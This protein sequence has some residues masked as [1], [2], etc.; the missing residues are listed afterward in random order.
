MAKDKPK[1]GNTKASAITRKYPNSGLASE[2]CIPKED[3][4]WLPSRNLYINHVL[5]GGLLYG[6]ILEIAGEESSGKTLLSLDFL[7]VAQSLGG[8]G[9]FVDAEHAFTAGWAETNGVQLD[10]LYLFPEISVER[11]GDWIADIGIL[12]RSKLKN[13][14]PIVLIVDSTAALDCEAN[15]NSTLVDGKAE[16]GNRAKAIYTMLRRRNELLDKLGICSIFINQLRKK[17]DAQFQDPDT[18]PGG[19]ALKFYASQRM[20]IYRGK[21]INRGSKTHPKRV[22][23]IVS[24]RVAKNKVAPPRPSFQTNVYFSAEAGD[25]VGFDRYMGL[26]ELF[27]GLEVVEKR[28]NAIY[29][30]DEKVATG[31]DNFDEVIRENSKLRAK[32]VSASGLNTVSKTRRQLESLTENL[33]DVVN[34]QKGGKDDDEG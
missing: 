5:G 2:I 34:I 32:L 14:E 33:Y 12:L 28:G 16:M 9:M 15:L 25:T 11:I 3:A 20:M 26:H 8:Y 21:Q 18:T 7:A 29:F 1:I 24:V 27:L 19:Q 31:M 23:N 4:I 17:L 10:K 6:R 30:N 22:G 13:N